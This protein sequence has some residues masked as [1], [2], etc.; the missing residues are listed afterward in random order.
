MN[1]RPS[2]CAAVALGRELLGRAVAAVGAALGQEPLRDLEVARPPLALHVRPV[3]RRRRPGPRPTRARPSAASAGSARSPRG[4]RASRRCPRCAARSARRCAARR[5]TRTAPC[6]RRPR[7]ADRLATAQT[8]C[9]QGWPRGWSVPGIGFSSRAVGSPCL[10]R[11][12]DLPGGRAGGGTRLPLAAGLPAEPARLEAGRALRRG[13]RSLP[14]AGG[15]AGHRRGQP[16]AL[17]DQPRRN[18]SA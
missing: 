17:P 18:R 15:G 12:R 3:R 10:E 13:P 1:G 16:R 9:G 7:A 8:A 5:A 4:A 6:G 11:R 2:R 14:R